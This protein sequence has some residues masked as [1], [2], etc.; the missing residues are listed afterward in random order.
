MTRRFTK[1][2]LLGAVVAGIVTATAAALAF[3]DASFFPSEGEVGTP[4]QHRF[5]ARGGSPPY[6]FVVL[7]GALPPGLTLRSD[8]L[9]S[10]TPT[11]SGSFSFWVELT[12]SWTT[13]LRAQREFTIAIAPDLRITT[14]GAPAATPGTPYS[15]QLTWVGGGT[16]TWS[17]SAGVLPPGFT[18]DQS[19]LLQGT[20][21]T[22]GLYDF[23]IF[24][25]DGKRSDTKRL[26]IAVRNK[27]AFAPPGAVPAAEVGVELTPLPLTAT[28]GSEKYTWE[29][30]PLTLPGGLRLDTEARIVGTPRVAGTFA[31]A[32]TVKDD[33]G[34]SA[35][36]EVALTIAPKLR[37]ATRRLP[38]SK[39][40]NPFSVELSVLGGVEPIRWRAVKGEGR[41]PP[42]VR[43]N[44]KTGLLAGKPRKPGR[45]RFVIEATDGFK[46]TAQRTL[47][48]VVR[49]LP[50]AKKA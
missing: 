43:L 46:V 47:T 2:L 12:D 40:G 18:L 19:G 26:L 44:R 29:V 6:T 23:T 11:Q 33:E 13:P 32:V 5:D 9:V 21:T 41:F 25:T 48:I 4:Y 7:S 31:I 27:L 16:I 37:I 34:R 24:I 14:E 30:D 3:T 35:T 20:P 22:V 45:Y 39:V 17:V 15:L 36:G 1:L 10:G 38:Q 42:G 50:R 8:G 49:A 28:G